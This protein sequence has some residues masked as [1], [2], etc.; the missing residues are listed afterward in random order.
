MNENFKKFGR[1]LLL[2]VTD[3]LIKIKI[4]PNTITLL[5]LPVTLLASY[6][7]AIG[8]L[9]IAGLTLAFAGLF[10]VLDGEVARR[11]NRVSKFGA[12]FDS[13]ID[14]FE[15]F[16][17]FGGIIYYYSFVSANPLF[18]ILVYFTLLGAIMTSYIRA[19]AE[20]VGY[21]PQSGPMDRPGRYIFIIIFSVIGGETFKYS[22]FVLLILVFITVVNRFR[23]FYLITNKE[24]RHG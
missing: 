17:V 2:P 8:K 3:L 19:R 23:E 20:G 12:F 21:S 5:G 14:R 13:T 24:E 4:T 7:Y 11:L 1:Q 6:F 10:D 16:F 15:E 18:A 22:M 9:R